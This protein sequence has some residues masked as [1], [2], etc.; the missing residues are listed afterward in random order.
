MGWRLGLWL[1]LCAIVSLLASVTEA[2]TPAPGGLTFFTCSDTHYQD[3]V[4][5]N[6]VQAALIDMMNAMPNKEYPDDLGGGKIG[7][8]RGVIVPGDLVDHG[9]APAKKVRQEWSLWNADFGLNGEGRLKF[10]VYEGYGNHD[11][12]TK[13]YVEDEIKA[14]NLKRKDVVAISSNGYHYAWEWDGIHFIQ[15]N[16]YPADERPSGVKG[17]PPR[18]AL[19]FLK[20]ELAKNVGKS[21]KPV[22]VTQ[23]YMPTDNWWTEPEKEAFFQVLK[24]YNVILIVHGHQGQG[25]IYDWKGLTVVD[26]NDFRGAGVFVVNIRGNEMR[27]VQRK[28]YDRWALKAKKTIQRPAAGER[29]A[30]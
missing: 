19:Q 28:P 20:E 30:N 18:F 9:Q 24:D 16:L 26:N 14:R 3:A 27:I 12:N 21:G 13:C 22:V 2:A 5:S 15:L 29:N 25:S 17:Q 1:A 4:E 23:H 10:P 11:L 8:P 7:I 6:K